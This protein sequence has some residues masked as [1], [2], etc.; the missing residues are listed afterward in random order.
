[1]IQLAG[2]SAAGQP[3]CQILPPTL[4]GYQ[5][6]C[7]YTINPGASGAWQ[8]PDLARARQLVR[9]SGTLGDKV[10]IVTGTGLA[11]PEA[12]AVSA[13]P[14]GPDPFSQRGGVA[15]GTRRPRDRGPGAMGSAV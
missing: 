15:L 6:S 14:C 13:G 7:P 10:T 3:T 8:A 11:L 2:G 5:P 4:P 9:Q 1:M 12:A